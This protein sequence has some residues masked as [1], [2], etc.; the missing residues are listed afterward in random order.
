MGA[1]RDARRGVRLFLRAFVWNFSPFSARFELMQPGIEIE[2][3]DD[4][5]WIAEVPV[6]PGCLLRRDKGGCR[7]V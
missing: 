2:Q 6:L 7:P 3:A 5:R 4:G 1:W